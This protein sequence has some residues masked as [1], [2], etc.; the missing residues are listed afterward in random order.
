[1]INSLN[2]TCIIIGTYTAILSGHNPNLFLL[3]LTNIFLGTIYWNELTLPIGV[4]E[5]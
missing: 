1:M 5:K 2:I 4:A 3:G